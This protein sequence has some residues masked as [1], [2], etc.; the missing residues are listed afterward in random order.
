MTYEFMSVEWV[1]AARAIGEEYAD[2]V[3]P[4]P[5]SVRVN[6]VITEAPGGGQIDAHLDTSSGTTVIDLGHLE[7]PDVTITV[8]YATAKALFVDQDPQAAMQ[9][10][11]AGKIKV[12]GDVA[13]LMALQGQRLAQP[14]PVAAE[15]AERIRAITAD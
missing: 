12:D 13:K 4:P 6:Q 7:A 14:D 10:F 1:A 3:P 11:L 5:L 9:A 15:A 8:D 2:R